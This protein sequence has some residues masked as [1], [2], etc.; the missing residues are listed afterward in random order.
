MRGPSV[1]KRLRACGYWLLERVP[2]I[3]VDEI[4]SHVWMI[5]AALFA[6]LAIYVLVLH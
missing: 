3:V 4:I 5:I 1:A 2:V 6:A